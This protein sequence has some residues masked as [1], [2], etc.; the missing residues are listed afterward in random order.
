MQF[1]Y[2][3]ERMKK[4]YLFSQ[5][6]LLVVLTSVVG[7]QAVHAQ[8]SSDPDVNNPVCTKAKDQTSSVSASD[9]AGGAIIAWTD[10]RNGTE[11]DVYAQR[12]KASGVLQ[13]KTDGVPIAVAANDKYVPVITG[14]GAGGAIIA[15]EDN[16]S[17]ISRIYAQRISASGLRLWTAAGDSNGIPVSNANNL[18]TPAIWGDGAGGAIIAWEDARTGNF[19]I[20]VQRLNPS[21]IRQWITGSDSN[22]VLVCNATNSQNN[23]VLTTDGSGGAIITWEDHRGSNADIYAQRINVNGV[24]QWIS[25]KDSNGVGICKTTGDQT[26]PKI[27]SSTDK[28]A[29]IT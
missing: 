4:C 13:W 27:I 10:Y 9:G 21:G 12:I 22:G 11:N 14:D 6:I 3:G 2:Y 20:Y 5:C 8:W 7:I 17:G 24:R 18:F 23:P 28:N 15:W 19:D 16:R 25:G 1:A 29:I 26:L